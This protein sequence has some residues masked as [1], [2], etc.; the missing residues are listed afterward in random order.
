MYGNNY[1]KAAL[2]VLKRAPLWTM[3]LVGLTRCIPVV[4]IT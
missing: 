2:K 1:R 3:L 4:P